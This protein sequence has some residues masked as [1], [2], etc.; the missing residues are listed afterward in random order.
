MNYQ[1]LDPCLDELTKEAI[2]ESVIQRFETCYDS[3]W[4]VL[5]RFLIEEFG[6]VETPNSP[7]PVF[8]L[9]NENGLLEVP[10]ERWLSYT[11]ARIDTAHDYDGEKAEACLR[12]VADFIDDAKHLHKAMSE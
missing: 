5:K 8:R 6:L 2:K 9:A 7:K 12:I 1:T 3:V 11:Q 4:K 10:I